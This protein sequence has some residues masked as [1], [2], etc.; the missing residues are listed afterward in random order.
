ME[1]HLGDVVEEPEADGPAGELGG[2]AGQGGQGGRRRH[3][4]HA[5]VIESYLGRGIITPED[6]EEPDHVALAHVEPVPGAVA[7]DDDVLGYQVAR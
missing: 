6:R 5:R 7:A 2:Q 3:G 1:I 4:A